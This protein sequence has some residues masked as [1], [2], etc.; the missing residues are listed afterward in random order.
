MKEKYLC[1]PETG[2]DL[3]TTE[4]A[5]DHL[6]YNY[7]SVRHIMR[8]EKDKPEGLKPWGQVGKTWL[9][10]KTDIETY[11]ISR[12]RVGTEDDKAKIEAIPDKLEAKIEPLSD[13]LKAEVGIDVGLGKMFPQDNKI[14]S[15]T[16]SDIPKIRASI[17]K[18]YGKDR[19]FAIT[20]ES[21]DGSLWTIKYEPQPWIESQFKK[22]FRKR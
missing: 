19:P 20:V 7:A 22:L 6:G 11:K 1:D 18:K 13:K 4:Q 21:P 12:K 16:W 9:F 10:R 15:F 2:E 3:L 8:I 5:A 17:R 14:E